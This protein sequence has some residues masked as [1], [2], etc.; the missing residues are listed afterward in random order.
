MVNMAANI[1]SPPEAEKGT[2]E[3]SPVATHQEALDSLS[4]DAVG[5]DWTEKEERQ[6]V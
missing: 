4:E 5:Q 3:K 6:V 1:G 2:S